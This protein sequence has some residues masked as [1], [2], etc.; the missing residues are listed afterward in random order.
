VRRVF[1]GADN[2]HQAMTRLLE[3]IEATA[4][5]DAFLASLPGAR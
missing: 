4:D 1:A 2:P 5:N 3:R